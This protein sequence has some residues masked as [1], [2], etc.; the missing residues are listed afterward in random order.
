M[1]VLD[2]CLHFAFSFCNSSF[3]LGLTGKK[4]KSMTT[5]LKKEVGEILLMEIRLYYRAKPW[6]KFIK[7]I[8]SRGNWL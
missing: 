4:I 3:L 1:F 6:P 5:I 8:V 2:L 7:T